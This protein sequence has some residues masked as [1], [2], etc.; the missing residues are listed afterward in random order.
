MKKTMLIAIIMFML[1]ACTKLDAEIQKDIDSNP[2]LKDN[3]IVVKVIS[4]ENG[5]VKL[6][7][8]S[9]FNNRVMEALRSG[10]SPND[11]YMFMDTRIKP[12]VQLEEV[13]KKRKEVKDIKWMAK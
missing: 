8:E 9:G 6:L 5:Y 12:L 3:N 11:I 10:K 7:V 13:L 4:V 2:F 1:F